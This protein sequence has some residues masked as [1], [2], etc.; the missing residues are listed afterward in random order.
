MSKI[1]IHKACPAV[2]LLLVLLLTAG[3]R[4][5]FFGLS[6]RKAPTVAGKAE[7]T[8]KGG[9]SVDRKVRTT[10]P[11]GRMKEQKPAPIREENF[12]A[13]FFDL[14]NPE[15]L[16]PLGTPPR[17]TDR[18]KG[19][20]GTGGKADPGSSI[21]SYRNTTLTEDTTWRGEVLVEGGVTIAPQTTLTV[22]N[23]TVVRF[24]GLSGS[25]T[26]AA[27]V[28][29]GRIVVNGTPA[30][31]V[32]FTST[33]QQAASGDWQG[34]V[35]TGSG[36]N[37][38]IAHCRVEGAE[39]GIDASFST[40][41]LKNVVFAGCKTG[42]RLQDTVALIDG[43]KAGECGTGM[44]LYD[45]EA[46][47]RSAIFFGNRLG[48]YAARTSLSLAN[49]RL[50]G[51]NLLALAADKSKISVSGNR[52]TANG[53][54]LGL[55]GCEGSVSANG[56]SRNAAYGILLK[57]SRVKVSFNNIEGN[58]NA[59]LRI[60]DGM[61]AAW[62]NALSANGEYDL[63]NAGGEEFRAI[64]NW[65]GTSSDAVIVTRI[66]DRGRDASRGKVLF[67][68]PLQARPDTVVSEQ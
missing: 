59:G 43:L 29:Q 64:G 36:K 7:F 14:R 48:I 17:S 12:L 33:Y 61:G 23:G 34:I 52:I 10:A 31:P 24:R 66:F 62:G 50:T 1:F 68:P 46:D 25:D 51:N 32:T 53:N 41:N 13:Q 49:S 45:C 3:C 6:K 16:V 54:G 35:L 30:R 27:L 39:T 38:R 44:I 40:I 28:V 67:F 65:W 47:I 37:N 9:K 4:N 57:E 18:S 8:E 42:V 55:V 20:T 2:I 60:E 26:R 15:D 19:I 21:S 63:Y 22:E 11:A 5:G 56:I 58:G